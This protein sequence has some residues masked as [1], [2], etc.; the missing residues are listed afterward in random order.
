MNSVVHELDRDTGWS[1]F[2]SRATVLC[3]RTFVVMD[4]TG[5]FLSQRAYPTMA[6]IQPRI[7]L[8]SEEDAASLF[9]T[10]PGME[11]LEVKIPT[12]ESQPTATMK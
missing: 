10:A 6:L 8:T 4:K 3:F 2:C 5:H 9:L 1:H 12:E 7:D 11:E